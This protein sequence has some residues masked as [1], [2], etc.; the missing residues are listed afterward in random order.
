MKLVCELKHKSYD[1]RLK[2]LGVSSLKKGDLIEIYKTL[3][4]KEKIDSHQLF[5]LFIQTTVYKDIQRYS[6]I[7]QAD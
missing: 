4:G 5:E 3:T 1:Q 7:S 2:V 6:T